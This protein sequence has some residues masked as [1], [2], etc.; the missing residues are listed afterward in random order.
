MRL[1]FALPILLLGACQVTKDDANDS[2]SVEYNQGLAENAAADVGNA[3]EAVA[4]DIANDVART[5]DKIENK[6]GDVDVDV[7]VSRDAPANTAANSN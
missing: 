7:D 6:V 3:A 1:A 5:G 4:N 2:V